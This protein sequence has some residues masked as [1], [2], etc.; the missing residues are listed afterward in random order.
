MRANGEL[1]FGET[2]DK[3]FIL[4]LNSDAWMILNL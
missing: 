3:A 4:P 2:D 1:Y